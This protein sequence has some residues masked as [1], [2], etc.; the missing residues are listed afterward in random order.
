MP[1]KNGTDYSSRLVRIP[2]NC[3]PHDESHSRRARLNGLSCQC[4]N[5][6]RYDRAM[7]VSPQVLSYKDCPE[8]PRYKVH[9]VRRCECDGAVAR[10]ASG[11][12]LSAGA[13]SQSGRNCMRLWFGPRRRFTSTSPK[14]T[15]SEI[16]EKAIDSCGRCTL[17]ERTKY[18]VARRGRFREWCPP[19]HN[20]AHAYS[21]CRY[22]ITLVDQAGGG[23]VLLQFAPHLVSTRV[24]TPV[25][26]MRVPCKYPASTL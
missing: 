18:C 6:S 5:T 19:V 11:S 23:T 8:R 7:S 21:P 2:L 14:S 3:Q 24:S 9:R 1:W 20:R 17:T 10:Q 26:T 12:L 4:K 15:R 16:N 25:S 22:N 13:R